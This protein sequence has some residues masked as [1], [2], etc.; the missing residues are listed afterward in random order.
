MSFIQQVVRGHIQ[1]PSVPRVVTELLLQTRQPRVSIHALADT[2]EQDPVIAART[3]QLANSPFYGGG[4]S[5][6]TIADA[7]VTLG[8]EGVQRIVLTVGMASVFTEVPGVN[9]RQFWVDATVAA[10]AARALA[11]LSP[12]TTDMAESAFLAGLLHA[13]GHLI[14]CACHPE[15]AHKSFDINR[16]MR[17]VLLTQVEQHCFGQVFP[18]V[19]AAW[20]EH[21]N[22]STHQVRGVAHQLLP[23]SPGAGPLAPLVH[24]AAGIAEGLAELVSVDALVASFEDPVL[25]AAAI[26]RAALSAYLDASVENMSVAPRLV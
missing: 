22:L 17:G 19:G 20:L 23:L 10:S 24:L 16:R 6:E 13:S 9:L 15:V 14:L 18:A 3:L 26:D 4:R 2:V 7:I 25:E 21:L 5:M 11:R 1:L 12:R 8:T